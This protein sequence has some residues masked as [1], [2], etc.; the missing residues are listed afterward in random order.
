MTLR[1][2]ILLLVLQALLCFAGVRLRSAPARG[3]YQQKPTGPLVNELFKD[4]DSRL[5][6][7]QHAA[8]RRM[9]FLDSLFRQSFPVV[10]LVLFREPLWTTFVDCT[11][12]CHLVQRAWNHG[13]PLTRSV[14]RKLLVIRLFRLLIR[15]SPMIIP[16]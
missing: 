11:I 15:Q 12:V 16:S 7:A 14:A 3:H 8:I 13:N 9:N 5:S 2:V 10:T 4:L 1:M 6:A